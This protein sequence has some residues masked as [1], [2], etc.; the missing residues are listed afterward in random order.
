MLFLLALGYI[1]LALIEIVMHPFLFTFLMLSIPL[2]LGA[3]FLSVARLS[4]ENPAT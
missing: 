2:V 3:L 1:S 4:K